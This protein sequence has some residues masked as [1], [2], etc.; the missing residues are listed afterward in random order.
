MNVL[1]LDYDACAFSTDG[2]Y[3]ASAVYNRL[4][5]KTQPFTGPHVVA[6]ADHAIDSLQWNLASNLILC[7]EFSKGVV[8]VYDVRARK[9][10]RTLRCG[11]FKFVAAEWIGRNNILLT[12][13]FHMALAV[14]NL[15]KNSTV[16]IEIPKPIWPCAVFDSDGTHMFVVSKI[17]GYEKLLMM[18]SQSLDRIIYVQDI[19]GPCNGLNKSPDN[20]YICVYNN[21]K[22]AILDFLSGN[23]IGSVE[24]I[25]LNTVSW[26]PN[27][28]YLAL[29]CSLGDIVVLASSN[30]FNV[31]FKLSRSS[32]NEDYDFFVESNGILIK[33][34]P[35]KTFINNVSAK[36]SSIVWSF[37]CNYLSTYEVDSTFL[38]IWE[39][40]K[41]ICVVEL[42]KKIKKMQ[43]CPSENKL[44][45]AYGTDLIFFWTEGQIPKLQTSPKLVD[46]VRVSIYGF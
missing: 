18:S 34:N 20:R 5:V 32:L 16:Y 3:V 19:I 29:G 6:T 42:S 4:I 30:E 9:W 23:I 27:S 43:W 22:L 12:L 35:S 31:E 45:V 11:Y 13:E 37:N 2:R 21:I 25:S 8:Q 44:C 33:T 36:I 7:T 38:C 24:Y 28:K 39:K 26:A 15:L 1:S 40:Y 41:L 10:I 14:F 46:G 17:N